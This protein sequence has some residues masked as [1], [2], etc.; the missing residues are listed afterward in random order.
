MAD[1]VLE[2][3]HM[4]VKPGGKQKIMQDIMYH[5]KVHYIEECGISTV[6][7]HADWM[8]ATLVSHLDFRDEKC[9]VKHLHGHSYGCF[10]CCHLFSQARRD[11]VDI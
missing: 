3:A 9:L 1:D 10:C 8:H 7:K 11:F 2:V 5:G 4:N 6:G